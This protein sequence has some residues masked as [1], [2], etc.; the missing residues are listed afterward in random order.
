[1]ARTFPSLLT[2][3]GILVLTLLF[4][5]PVLSAQRQKDRIPPTAPTNLVVTA[6]TEQ[7]ASLAW[8]PS[9]DNSGRF[10]YIIRGGESTVTVGQEMTS[11]TLEDLQSGKTYTFRVY[12]K[13]AAGNLSAP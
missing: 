2:A 5:S 13:D 9:T 12:A 3:V 6:T 1:M 8:D 4:G 7:S 11:H 10:H